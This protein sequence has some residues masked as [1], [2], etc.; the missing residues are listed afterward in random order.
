MTVDLFR[1]DPMTVASAVKTLA[2]GSCDG[3]PPPEPQGAKAVR[4]RQLVTE[5]LEATLNPVELHSASGLFLS[6]LGDI[7]WRAEATDAPPWSSLGLGGRSGLLQ[8]LLKEVEH[9]PPTLLRMLG[10]S[11]KALPRLAEE[12]V[13]LL[14]EGAKKGVRLCDLLPLLQAAGLLNGDELAELMA[15]LGGAMPASEGVAV[16]TCTTEQETQYEEQVEAVVDNHR[17][18]HKTKKVFKKSMVHHKGDWLHVPKGTKLMPLHKARRLVARMYGLRPVGLG[19]LQ[20]LE[21]TDT[22]PNTDVFNI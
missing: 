11:K 2:N 12:L 17:H 5:V 16:P 19:I 7:N 13:G 8:L 1:N 4:I 15:A 9:D 20:H 10:N 14:A 21:M 3:N 18:K 6:K 22:Y